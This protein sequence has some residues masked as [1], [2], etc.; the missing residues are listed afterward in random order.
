MTKDQVYYYVKEIRKNIDII[1]QGL[2]IDVRRVDNYIGKVDDIDLLK[3][4][5][6]V[7]LI[8]DF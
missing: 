7:K 6:I 2:Q 8:L 1:E 5:D 3:K 4:L